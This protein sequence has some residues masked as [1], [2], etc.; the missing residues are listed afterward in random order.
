MK[1]TPSA[2]STK[3]TIVKEI[4]QAPRTVTSLVEQLGKSEST[5][6][7]ALKELV[8]DGIAQRDA[9]TRT[10]Q[11]VGQTEPNAEDKPKRANHGYARNTS[12]DLKA[13]ARDIAV[14]EFLEANGESTLKDIAQSLG[15]TVRAARHAAAWRLVNRGE[16]E[17]V[18]K[19]FY[20]L[21]EA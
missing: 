15:I 12:E 19:G 21:T 1:G 3:D 2:M 9:A 17:Q 6:R 10:F 4:T 5:V 18:R 8:E 7:A 14:V 13:N 20:A 16:V 11:A